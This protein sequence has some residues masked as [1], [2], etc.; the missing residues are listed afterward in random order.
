[1]GLPAEAILNSVF[2]RRKPSQSFES[3]KGLFLL[4][5]PFKQTFRQTFLSAKGASENFKNSYRV[6]SLLRSV[7]LAQW[8]PISVPIFFVT[9]K[10]IALLEKCSAKGKYFS[11]NTDKHKHRIKISYLYCNDLIIN[12]LPEKVGHPLYELYHNYPALVYG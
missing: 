10:P 9:V 2:Q 6:F 12:N 5:N 4:E 11:C 8:L 3:F 1:M 7:F